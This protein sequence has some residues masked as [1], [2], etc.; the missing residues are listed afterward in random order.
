MLHACPRP[1][2]L[3]TVT[4]SSYEAMAP[5]LEPVVDFFPAK[6]KAQMLDVT[7]AVSQALKDGRTEIVFA[8]DSID[9][10]G[11]PPL[12]FSSSRTFDNKSTLPV[13]LVE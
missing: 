2:D 6:G 10:T 8:V 11:Q 3:K 12:R 7:A 5:K 9:E 13:L 4:W 1:P